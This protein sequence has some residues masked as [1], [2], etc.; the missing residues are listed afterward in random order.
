M[1]L[2]RKLSKPN[3]EWMN[4]SNSFIP[5]HKSRQFSNNSNLLFVPCSTSCSD[6]AISPLLKRK[7]TQ[8]LYLTPG[9]TSISSFKS[10]LWSQMQRSWPKSLGI[11]PRINKFTKI[12]KS[13]SLSM[14]SSRH[15]WEFASNTRAFSTSYRRRLKMIW[16]TGKS[17]QSSKKI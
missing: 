16:P 7:T 13:D 4:K 3:K 1:K 8:K 6:Q 14:N 17:M 11:L 12:M 2:T 5:L 15:Y 9:I 10:T